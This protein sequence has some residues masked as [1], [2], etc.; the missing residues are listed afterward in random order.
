MIWLGSVLVIA[1][2][3]ALYRHD[4]KQDQEYRE[5]NSEFDK[6]NITAGPL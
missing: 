6:R 4:R 2:A 1:V 3:V 5:K